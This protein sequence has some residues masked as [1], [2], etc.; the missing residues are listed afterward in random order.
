MSGMTKLFMEIYFG[1]TLQSVSDLNYRLLGETLTSRI[2]IAF[3]ISF[4]LL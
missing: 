3:L 1:F 2:L 4:S